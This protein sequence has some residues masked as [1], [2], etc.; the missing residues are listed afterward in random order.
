MLKGEKKKR[1]RE[2][3]RREAAGK[4]GV[5]HRRNLEEFCSFRWSAQN[6]FS[7]ASCCVPLVSVPFATQQNPRWGD[8]L[9]WILS[10]SNATFIAKE[11]HWHRSCSTKR[12]SEVTRFC[13]AIGM[14]I[15]SSISC[16]S[17]LGCWWGIQTTYQKSNDFKGAVSKQIGLAVCRNWG[18]SLAVGDDTSLQLLGAE[19]IHL[20]ALEWDP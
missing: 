19:W 5:Q 9:R 4:A 6:L 1:G 10:I 17:T 7:P 20:A 15:S 11:T 14:A 2:D 18:E 13:C 16:V 12:E 8:E 3:T